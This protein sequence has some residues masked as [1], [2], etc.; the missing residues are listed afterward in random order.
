M[1][2]WGEDFGVEV[3]DGY[4]VNAWKVVGCFDDAF[5]FG[6]VMLFARP[7]ALQPQRE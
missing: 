6:D 2:S 1:G 5:L 3:F 4:D 7:P